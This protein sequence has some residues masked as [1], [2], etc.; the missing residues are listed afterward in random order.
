MKTML[1]RLVLLGVL[2]L[3]PVQ[4]WG[5]I[6]VVSSVSG[7]STDANT[8]TTGSFNSTGANLVVCGIS[9]NAAAAIPVVTDSNANTYSTLTV[10]T[11]TSTRSTLVYAINPTVGAGHTFTV[12]RA[13]GFQSIGCIAFSGANTSSPADAGNGAFNNS[14]TSLATGSISAAANTVAVSVLCQNGG[15]SVN[16]DN[17]FTIQENVALVGGQ[18]YPMVLAYKLSPG[19]VNPT[20]SWTTTSTGTTAIQSFL[21]DGAAAPAG[22]SGLFGSTEVDE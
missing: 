2:L 19:T 17:S 4:G 16:I 11:G 20:W 13:S 21:S 15:T 9:S 7:G 22:G 3:L 8:F 1:T 6:A 12:T 14:T 10:Y 5:A 18:H